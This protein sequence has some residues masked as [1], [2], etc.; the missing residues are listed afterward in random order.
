MGTSEGLLV[1][2]KEHKVHLKL[3]DRKIIVIGSDI[4]RMGMNKYA[5]LCIACEGR[6]F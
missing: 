6:I 1:Q 3:R 2:I 4:K 5:D